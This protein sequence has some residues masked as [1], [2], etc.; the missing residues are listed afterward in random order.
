MGTTSPKVIRV[1]ESATFTCY[2]LTELLNILSLPSSNIYQ[3]QESG[4][5]DN[6]ISQV[7]EVV[8]VQNVKPK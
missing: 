1:P 6:S 5:I 7:E 3:N 8:M 2:S 4:V